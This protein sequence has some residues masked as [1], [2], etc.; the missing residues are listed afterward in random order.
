[1]R[2]RPASATQTLN[3]C[4][5]MPS[6]RHPSCRSRGEPFPLIPG[7]SFCSV[8]FETAR[9]VCRSKTPA[10]ESFKMNLP[11]PEF[12]S[13]RDL[14]PPPNASR[15]VVLS[16]T[17]RT[18]TIVLVPFALGSSLARVVEIATP[19]ESFRRI[20]H[21][22][23]WL[24]ATWL[25]GPPTWPPASTTLPLFGYP[26]TSWD[27]LLLIPVNRATNRWPGCLGRDDICFTS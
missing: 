27:W 10:E 18:P 23:P 19:S 1:M 11:F 8:Y 7:R 3:A 13:R 15:L 6:V 25:P 16:P 21:A 26:E 22:A 4:A 17:P 24:P 5:P 2:F 20:C 12:T 14:R 9:P